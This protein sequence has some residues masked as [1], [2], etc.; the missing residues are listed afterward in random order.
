MK[1]KDGF[2]AYNTGD[3]N[4]LV[5]TG[6]AGKSFNG[7]VRNNETAAFIAELLKNEI[8]EDEI[9]NKILEEYDVDEKTARKDVKKLLDTFKREGFLE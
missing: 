8:T 9:V 5:A 7:I 6:E 2:I 1:L 3:E 4:L